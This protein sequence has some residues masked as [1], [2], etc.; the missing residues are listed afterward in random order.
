[1][2]KSEGQGSPA[3]PMKGWKNNTKMYL[4]EL[5]SAGTV[6]IPLALHTER[7]WNL[8]NMRINPQDS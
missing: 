6:R 4:Q 1:V 3:R 7:W 8:V 5:C 2:A